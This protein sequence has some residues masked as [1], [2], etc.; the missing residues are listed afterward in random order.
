MNQN[1][2]E[3]NEGKDRTGKN[4]YGDYGYKMRRNVWRIKNGHGFGH[5]DELSI[6]HPATFPVQL[7]IA[8]A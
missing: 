7:A 6:L 2:D 4:S 5:S 3:S 8:F 1:F